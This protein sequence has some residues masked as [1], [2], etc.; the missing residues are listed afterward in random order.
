[1]KKQALSY[2]PDEYTH[3]ILFVEFG[4]IFTKFLCIYPIMQ[5]FTLIGNYLLDIP[6]QVQN[7][8]VR[9]VTMAKFL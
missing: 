1:M 3:N 6:L 9:L 8:H 5:K 2:I 7:I 4:N